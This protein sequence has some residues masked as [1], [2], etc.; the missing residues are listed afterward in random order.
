MTCRAAAILG[1]LESQVV[2][3][4]LKALDVDHLP[5]RMQDRP[6]LIEEL[7][8]NNEELLHLS[9]MT[10]S[11]Q[12]Y[13]YLIEYICFINYQALQDPLA[14]TQEGLNNM[15]TRITR[16]MGY[17]NDNYDDCINGMKILADDLLNEKASPALLEYTSWEQLSAGNSMH[18]SCLYLQNSNQ[19][20]LAERDSSAAKDTLFYKY[21]FEANFDPGSVNRLSNYLEANHAFY[22]CSSNKDKWN[23]GFHQ[24]CLFETAFFAVGLNKDWYK[25]L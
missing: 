3:F 12:D 20:L 1:T 19:S 4:K 18:L 2:P 21:W 10:S 16:N 9:L 24:A 6:T 17:V 25:G 11:E 8:V 7:I 13:L 14:H 5:M 23:T 22:D 15:A